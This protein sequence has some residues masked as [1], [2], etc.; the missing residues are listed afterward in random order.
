[1]S[2]VDLDY[3][4]IEMDDR[5]VE[6][7]TTIIDDSNGKPWD[8][9]VLTHGFAGASIHM[10]ALLPILRAKY[11]L[12]LFDNLSFG[13]NTKLDYCSGLESFEKAEA[14]ILEFWESWVKAMGQRLPPKFYLAAHSFG[15]YQASLFACKH[16][17][18]IKKLL[19][20]SP[21]SFETYDA[22]KYDPY[23]MRIGD[24]DVP[25]TKEQTDRKVKCFRDGYHGF[26]QVHSVPVFLFRT[27]LWKIANSCHQLSKPVRR[28]MVD[29]TAICFY[30]VSQPDILMNVT[31]EYGSV[32]KSS[33]MSKNKFGNPS[34]D[35]PVAFIF[36]DS[37]WHGTEGADEVV[38]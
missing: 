3:I 10:V 24:D 13:S 9:L 26:T 28:A 34:I 17:D 31:C 30:S 11:R 36:G 38:R 4:L 8:T 2:N 5:P 12:V 35:F 25:G 7:R 37:D 32:G 18:R 1:M 23:T 22:D 20:M 19:L 33:M 14:W 6:V 16:P 29:H 15:G 27:Y 21:T